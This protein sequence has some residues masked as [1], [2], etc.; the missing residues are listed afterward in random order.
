M[1]AYINLGL[2]IV[3]ILADAEVANLTIMHGKQIEA[4]N[5]AIIKNDKKITNTENILQ[6]DDIKLLKNYKKDIQN[7]KHRSYKL[8]LSKNDVIKANTI[9]KSKIKN[10]KTKILVKNDMDKYK[11]DFN[12]HL[13]NT[14]KI[15]TYTKKQ[16]K[17]NK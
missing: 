7:I 3:S 4:N 9:I 11:R 15:K 12:K 10:P 8:I 6:K 16:T 2:I 1:A 14:K 17:K 5:N 13:K